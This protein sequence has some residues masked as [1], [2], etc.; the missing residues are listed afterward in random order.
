MV[1][2]RTITILMLLAGVSL[3]VFAG[4]LMADRSTQM[5]ENSRVEQ[6]I[7]EQLDWYKVRYG[8]S[9][10]Q[11]ERVRAELVRYRQKFHEQLRDLWR[12]NEAVFQALS[13][14]KGKRIEAIV[15]S[16]SGEKSD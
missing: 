9:D 8:L 10:P 5:D 12:E 1:S 3:G 14:E 16:K 11:A 6:A 13:D 15:G 7:D 2:L 4:T